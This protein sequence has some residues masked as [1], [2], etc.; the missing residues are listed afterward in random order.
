MRCECFGAEKKRI[1]TSIDMNDEQKSEWVSER[2]NEWAPSEWNTE[3]VNV[4]KA[5]KTPGKNQ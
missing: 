3:K 4:T 2:A 1:D 5:Q